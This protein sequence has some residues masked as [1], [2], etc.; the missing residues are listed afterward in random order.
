MPKE[1][2]KKQPSTYV[3]SVEKLPYDPMNPYP[4]ALTG[5]TSEK[6]TNTFFNTPVTELVDKGQIF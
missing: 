3:D 4:D 2:N 5:I 1:R 6:K